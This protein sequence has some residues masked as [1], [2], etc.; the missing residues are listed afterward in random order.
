MKHR[1]MQ[2]NC[3]QKLESARNKAYSRFPQLT[4]RDLCQIMGKLAH[5]HYNKKKYIIL[6]LEKE[7]YNGLIENSLN[8]FTVYRWLLLERVPQDIQFQLK[9]ARISQKKA[10]SEAF[11]R[12]H[13]GLKELS[14]GI[15]ECGLGLIARM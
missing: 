7:L 9:Q 13:E 10:V 2:K 4:G 11:K 8:P 15:R 6:G 14:E 3:L 5:Y 12:R 1:D